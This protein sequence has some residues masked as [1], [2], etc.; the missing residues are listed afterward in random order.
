M[1]TYT[2]NVLGM[3]FISYI[4]DFSVNWLLGAVIFPNL[5]SLLKHNFGPFCFESWTLYCQIPFLIFT[6][7]QHILEHWKMK[8]KIKT[9]LTAQN[10]NQSTNLDHL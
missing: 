7:T 9:R 4:V 6:N 10:S 5:F 1:L 3:F 8:K 2:D